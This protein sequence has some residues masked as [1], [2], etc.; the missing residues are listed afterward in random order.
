LYQEIWKDAFYSRQSG[1][2]EKGD[3]K[4]TKDIVDLTGIKNFRDMFDP[5]NRI[6]V[7][8]RNQ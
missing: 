5:N 7:L 8:K 3:A 4:I 1:A 6:D 2:Y